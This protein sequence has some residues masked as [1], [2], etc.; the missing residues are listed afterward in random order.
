MRA[1]TP[2]NPMANWRPTESPTR[3][4]R[5]TTR[6]S[7]TLRH[8]PTLEK[9]L[10]RT[11][12]WTAE[13][14]AVPDGATPASTAAIQAVA[15]ARWA[16]CVRRLESALPR[17]T[18]SLRTRAE[19]RPARRGRSVST[20]FS[21]VPRLSARHSTT[22]VSVGLNLRTRRRVRTW[23][24]VR[25]AWG[26]RHRRSLCPASTFRRPAAR[27]RNATVFRPAYARM[28]APARRH[29]RLSTRD[30]SLA[31]PSERKKP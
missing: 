28:R 8:W 3:R 5:T 4:S 24:T 19:R 2:R 15:S 16:A 17:P 31:R 7:G 26:L 11:P 6:G 20:R 23:A 14:S 27:P 10:G 30:R 13:C 22:R 21:A 12:S 1:W 29:A 25:A 9:T 18:R